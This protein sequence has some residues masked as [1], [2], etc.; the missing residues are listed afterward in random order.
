MVKIGGINFIDE[1]ARLKSKQRETVLQI[2]PTE[3][4]QFL[5][6]TSFHSC[7]NKKSIPFTQALRYKRIC[8][9]TD[10][11]FNKLEKWLMEREYSERIVKMQIIKARGKSGGNFLK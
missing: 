4:L 3:T 9:S 6:S 5:D 8:S 11:R 1:N 7:Y 10:Q 2:T